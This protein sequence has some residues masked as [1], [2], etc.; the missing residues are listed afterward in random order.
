M[1]DKDQ[2][3][4]TVVTRRTFLRQTAK[5]AAALSVAGSLPF[6]NNVTASA[7]SDRD[8]DVLIK[9][10]TLY[11]GTLKAPWFADIGVKGG[12]I[13][14]LGDLAK[15]QATKIIEAKSLAVTPGFIDVHTHCDMA[16]QIMNPKYLSKASPMLKGNY[17][18]IYQGVTTVVTGNCGMGMPRTD[19]WF[20]R[21]KALPFG[22]NVAHLAPHGEIRAE[23]FGANQPGELSADQLG[24]LKRRFTEEMEKGAIGCSLGL[25]YAPGLLS[26]TRELIEIAGVVA[27]HNGLAAIHLRNETG[28][29]RK[30]GK[31]EIIASLEEAILIGRKAGIPIEISHLKIAAPTNSIPAARILD[32]I[33]R[34]RYD[35]LDLHA[36]QYPYNAGSTYI[37]Y[38]IPNKFKANDYGVKPEFHSQQGRR[39]IKEAVEATFSYLPPEKV[40]IAFYMGHREL[41]GKTI[42]EIA[43]IQGVTPSESYVE[44]VCQPSCPLG[45]F[46]SMDPTTVREIAS[47][48]HIITASDGGTYMKG[49]LKPHPRVY[50]TFPHKLCLVALDNQ[51]MSIQAAIRTMT[52]MPAEKFRIK[53][54]G[55]I[56]KGFFADIAVIDLAGFKDL[57]TYLQPHQYAAGVKHLLINGVAAITDGQ[58]T[59]LSGG[60]ALAR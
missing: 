50:G 60:V 20:D 54:R 49:A 31:P 2:E 52:S 5:V 48:D 59:N 40:L 33:E 32:I 26:A 56:E 19:Q 6:L 11:D 27:R 34:A 46:F 37:S 28:K 1:N 15:A 8:F 36:D 21:V 14:A 3:R 55:K 7:S 39:E 13:V 16:F 22:T 35:G 18:Y 57:A 4:K 45:I 17:N 53:N 51:W 38:L 25:E 42:K 24:A 47:R 43:E 9:G 10:G 29:M 12:R 58:P 41:E 23:L 44:M 30:D